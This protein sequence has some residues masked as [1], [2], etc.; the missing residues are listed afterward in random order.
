MIYVEYHLFDINDILLS[1][2]GLRPCA[3]DKFMVKLDILCFV[4]LR[5]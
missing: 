5:G 1:S 2:F 3:C 4:R